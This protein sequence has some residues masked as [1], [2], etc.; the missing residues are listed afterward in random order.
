M[1]VHVAPVEVVGLVAHGDGA[2]VAADPWGVLADAFV[3][4]ELNA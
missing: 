4:G 1:P 3:A 2:A